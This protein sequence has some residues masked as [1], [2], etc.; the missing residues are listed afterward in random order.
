MCVFGANTC[1][2]GTTSWWCMAIFMQIF[3]SHLTFFAAAAR[4]V[5]RGGK[6]TR[7]GNSTEKNKMRYNFHMN[8]YGTWIYYDFV[9]PRLTLAAFRRCQSGW[10]AEKSWNYFCKKRVAR[11]AR[12]PRERVMFIL[13]E[14][15][16]EILRKHIFPG[17]ALVNFNGASWA[18]KNFH[19]FDAAA[20][21]VCDA[22]IVY[23]VPFMQANN[24]SF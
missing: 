8:L 13:D 10:R 4:G 12:A 15:K 14:N 17:E 19:Y 24:D 23:P 11:E 2:S 6:N 7:I 21:V 3:S 22:E 1:V 18:N 16:F 9:P 20:R 5:E